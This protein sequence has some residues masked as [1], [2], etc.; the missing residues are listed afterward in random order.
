MV[1][2]FRSGPDRSIE[3][4]SI[5]R[6]TSEA[7]VDCVN[8]IIPGSVDLISSDPVRQNL[9]MPRADE[10]I[11][12]VS[13]F[14]RDQVMTETE[15]RTSFLSRVSANSLDIIGREF[16]LLPENRRRE[17][18]ALLTFFCCD[19]ADNDADL[20]NLRWRL[21]HALRDESQPLDDKFLKSYLRNT[22]VNQVAIDQPRY[23]GFQQALEQQAKKIS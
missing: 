7:L 6:R 16:D 14:L 3:R 18:A 1:G 8:L 11:S 4:A 10:L 2:Q 15:G 9:D 5:G 21:V 12:A 20:E 23:S 19:A 22:V 17:H 13:D